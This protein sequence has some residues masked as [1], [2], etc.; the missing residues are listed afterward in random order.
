MTSAPLNVVLCWHM[1]QP[2]Y[3]VDGR[4]TQPW[5]YL[6]AIK[7]YADMAAHL[8]TVPGA[9]AV[10]NFVPILLEQIDLYR[11]ALA[12]FIEHG[13]PLDDPLLD[14]LARLD[15]PNDPHERAALLEQCRHVNEKH[16]LG[17][18]PAYAHLIEMLSPS[19]HARYLNDAYFADLL[20]WFHLAWLGE[21]TRRH[22]PRIQALLAKEHGYSSVDRRVLVGVIRELLDSVVER[23][24]RL[25]ADARVELAVSPW[26]H[27]IL[28]LLL[29]YRTARAAL[30]HAD[31]PQHPEYPGGADRVRW[32]LERA[33][34][35]ATQHFGC[36]PGGCWPSEGAISAAAAEAIAAAG[37]VWCASGGGVL[38]NSLAAGHQTAECQHRPFEAG[39]TACFFRDD[40]LSDLIGFTYCDW[41]ADDAVANLIGHLET[42]GRHCDR[43][44][45]V[46]AIVLDGENAWESYPH[47][48]YEFLQALY[49]GLAQH[50]DLRLTTFSDYLRDHPATERLREVVA[51]SWV[52]G[53][54]STWMGDADKNRAWD[55][56]SIAKQHYDRRRGELVNAEECERLLAI[57]E[58]S[59]WFWWLGEHNAAAVVARFEALFRAHLRVLYHALG[60]ALPAEL[61]QPLSHGDAAGAVHTMRQAKG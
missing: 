36:E 17:R 50:A 8:E 30:P 56:L 39:G 20:V 43:P 31:L 1:H 13:T 10:V 19:A 28:P 29:D 14:A 40:G 55:L 41:H 44:D 33:R 57:C 58:G 9:R 53:T 24:R 47:N 27:P 12:Q 60:V 61:E 35:V 6:H 59:D 11:T 46:V 25:Q 45:A 26:A 42:I 16:V 32:H 51:G 38:A 21:H 7:D 15:L 54:L 34:H 3:R 49:R 37:F 52:Y 18:Y 48:G 4:F 5:V 2:W 22:D 23:Y